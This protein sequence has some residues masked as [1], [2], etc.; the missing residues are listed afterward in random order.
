MIF[1]QS[2]YGISHNN[3]K[4]SKEEH[5]EL[6]VVALDRLASKTM[7]WILKQSS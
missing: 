4:D 1:V 7:Q 2:F 5:L 6:S 3:I